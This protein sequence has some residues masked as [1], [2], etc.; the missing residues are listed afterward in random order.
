MTQGEDF[1]LRLV[2]DQRQHIDRKARLQRSLRE[3]TVEHDLRIGIL[4]QFNDDSHAVA[5]GFVTQVGDTLQTL[6]LDLI[7][8]IFYQIFLI[9][10]IRQLRNNNTDSV[11]S[12]FFKFGATAH[13]HSAAAG[14]VGGTDSASAHNDAACREIRTLDVLHQIGKR[15]L[16]IVQNTQAGVDDLGEVVRRD[17]GRHADCDAV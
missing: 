2:I 3:Q 12:V 11:V 7:G 13:D 5:V 14:L 15:R 6:L 10:L 1:R 16:R 4:F 9:D 8:D 17:V